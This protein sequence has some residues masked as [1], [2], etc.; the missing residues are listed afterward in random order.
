MNKRIIALLLTLVLIISAF[1]GCGPVNNKQE[2]K[3]QLVV[4][5]NPILSY[6]NGDN[7]I[8]F[9]DIKNAMNTDQNTASLTALADDTD[10]VWVYKQGENWKKRGIY[11][12][13]KWRNGGYISADKLQAY[14]FSNDGTIS[15]MPY[16]TQ[17]AKLNTYQGE[18]P[19][20]AGILISVSGN[21]EEALG[22][23]ITESG[24]IGIPAGK[25]TAIESVGGVKTGFLA[26]DGTE[27]SAVIKFIV[28]SRR[29]LQLYRRRRY[30][31]NRACLSRYS[32]H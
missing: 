9:N 12:L 19:T 25:I 6:E 18:T 17:V 16:T 24:T 14:T 10:L 21:E 3:P 8:A 23:Q 5:M 11:G 15:L 32:R 4:A 13:D 1:A 26:E 29:V 22:Y 2:R 20:A 30:C 7:I 31:Y 27:R 28:N